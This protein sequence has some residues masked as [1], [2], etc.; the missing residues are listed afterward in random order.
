MV[1]HDFYIELQY[2]ITNCFHKYENISSK[3]MS[4]NDSTKQNSV[5]NFRSF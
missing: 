2:N 4:I 1:I 5:F 3:Y